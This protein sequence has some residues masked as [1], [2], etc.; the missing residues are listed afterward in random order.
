MNYIDVIATEIRDAVPSDALPPGPNEG[1]F[2]MYAVLLLAKGTEVSASDVHNA[3]A[4][5]MAGQDPEHDS[6]TPYSALSRDVRQ[7]DTP[8]VHAIREIARRKPASEA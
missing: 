5:W 7:E 1:L 8:F 6:I 2:R 3:W 4:A